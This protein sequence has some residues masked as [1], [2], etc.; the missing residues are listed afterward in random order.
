MGKTKYLEGINLDKQLL[1]KTLKYNLKYISC[2][3]IF[4]LH[5]YF[6]LFL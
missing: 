5:Y 2:D 4:Y 3:S 1:D 6:F